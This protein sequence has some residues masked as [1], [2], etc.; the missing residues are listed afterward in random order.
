[1][2]VSV[3]SAEELSNDDSM[4]GLNNVNSM[5]ELSLANS[6][7]EILGAGNS[8]YVK[9]GATGGDGSEDSPYGNLKTAYNKAQSGDAIYIM[10]GTY[11]G[12][13]NLNIEFL[14]ENLQLKAYA[15]SYPVFDGQ[16]TNRI[17]D[18][19]AKGMLISGL[20][21]INAVS[22]DSLGVQGSVMDIYAS[23]VIID[24]CTFK[25]NIAAGTNAAFQ[26]AGA[27]Y[28]YASGSNAI[29]K[30]SQ[31]INNTCKK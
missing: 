25:N 1:M 21:F 5:D 14:K 29:I 9:A 20:I 10:N 2:V 24:N 11:N 8:W 31:F 28:V 7:D 17:F 6:G 23:N 27:I 26:R 13:N 30:N 19:S 22:K 16:N 4:V 15:D 12:L 3:S 18:I